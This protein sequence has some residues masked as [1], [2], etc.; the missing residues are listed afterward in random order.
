MK[1]NIVYVIQEIPG[2]QS[3]NPKINIM[4]ASNYGEMKF[5]FLTIANPKI[6]QICSPEASRRAFTGPETWARASHC[7]KPWGPPPFVVQCHL[8]KRIWCPK[9]AKL[10]LRQSAKEQSCGFFCWQNPTASPL[11][12]PKISWVLLGLSWGSLAAF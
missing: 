11:A 2:T 5:L 8:A 10:R 1:E 6:D 3:G 7:A 9:G 4:G 12:P